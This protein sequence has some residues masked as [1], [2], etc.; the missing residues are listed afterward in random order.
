MPSTAGS[1]LDLA[2]HRLAAGLLDEQKERDMAQFMELTQ[3]HVPGYAK[4]ASPEAKARPW[5]P[6]SSEAMHASS[7]ARVGFPVRAYS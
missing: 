1:A 6:P 4:A 2:Q 7:A 5:L 3:F